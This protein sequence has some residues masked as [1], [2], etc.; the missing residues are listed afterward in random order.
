M[1]YT[2]LT[3]TVKQKGKGIRIHALCT[4]SGAVKRNFRTKNGFGELAKINI[5]LDKQ[6]YATSHKTIY[7]PSHDP[8]SAASL[9][10]GSFLT[11]Q[12]FRNPMTI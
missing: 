2:N 6:G 12:H 7:L 5:L 1:T 11:P 4:G 10:S 9:N 8:N 3:T